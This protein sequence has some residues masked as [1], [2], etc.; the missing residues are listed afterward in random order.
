MMRTPEQLEQDFLAVAVGELDHDISM[1][2]AREILTAMEPEIVWTEAAIS[3][4]LMAAAGES[5]SVGT[6]QPGVA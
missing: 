6:Y 4:A 1:Q 3:E 2:R 5:D